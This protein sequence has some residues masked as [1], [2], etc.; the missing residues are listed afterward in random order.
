L[1]GD[2]RAVARVL[3]FSGHRIDAP[4]RQSPRFPSG[5]AH[6]A[7][8]LIGAVVRHEKELA[9]AAPV[10]GFAGGASGGDIIFHE[11]CEELGI[12]TTV[13]LGLPPR[14]FCARSVADAGPE[15]TSRFDRLCKTHAVRVLG[16]NATGGADSDDVWQQANLWILETALAVDADV[17]SLI[18][19][20]DGR[21]GDGPGG[22]EEM[23]RAARER[24]LEVVRLD[25]GPL[26]QRAEAERSP[27]ARR[28]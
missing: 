9:G 11:T 25:A 3:V 4:G 21:G 22:T 7:A 13:M 26:A 8:E 20:W 23:V 6:E 18:V 14:L 2:A 16:D 12:P 24:G 27:Q 15:W 10:V 19:L 1:H 5:A 28:R 17:H